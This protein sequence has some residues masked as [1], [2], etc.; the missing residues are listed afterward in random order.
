VVRQVGFRGRE[1]CAPSGLAFG[2][3]DGTAI[4]V[5]SRP[6]V[7]HAASAA[8][9][10]RERTMISTVRPA[11]RV[12][13]AVLVMA[14]GGASVGG[15][16]LAQ[17]PA[18]APPQSGF[19]LPGQPDARPAP[20]P[21][22]PMIESLLVTQTPTLTLDRREINLGSVLDSEKQ[23][24]RIRFRNTGRAML[25]ITDVKG[26]CG[27]TVPALEKRTYAPGEGGELLVKY[28]PH[29]RRGPQHQTVTI[30]SNDPAN[31]RMEIA[32]K[33]D[34]TPV[35][36]VEPMLTQFEA[37]EKAQV[38]TRVIE[39]MGLTPDFAVTGV[40]ISGTTALTATVGEPAMRE[41]DGRMLRVVPVTVA[42]KSDAAPG[43]FAAT[44]TVR[45][46]DAR[47]AVMNTQAMG[48]IQ[49]EL[50]TAPNPIWLGLVA[51]GAPME[52]ELRLSSR[53]G[54]PFMVLGVESREP[55]MR[56][57]KL[58]FQP[59]LSEGEEPRADGKAKE[60]L[61]RVV[62]KAPSQQ[63]A[64]R[65]ELEIRTDEPLEERVRVP[66]FA[67]VREAPQGAA[68][69][70]VRNPDGTP[71]ALPAPARAPAQQ[72]PAR[73]AQ[74]QPQPQPGQGQPAR[75]AQPVPVPR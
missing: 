65:G 2:R 63:M 16:A 34:V 29:N 60:W 31:P 52:S 33:V 32:V 45:T 49:G 13:V 62:A 74:P 24:V 58:T 70:Q 18:N 50:N 11:V 72:A 44:V 4:A 10:T 47:A 68:P 3:D 35:V 43:R 56:D 7:A 12:G 15:V 19:P 17:M 37:V 28:D 6:G 9:Q 61:I 67:N 23:E 30:T 22:G 73:A 26:S 25:N 5:N 41:V 38:T 21:G 42:T 27:C 39:V 54:K 46:N 59:V 69:V 55:N 14:C 64:L 57:A 53:S 36:R 51:P 8:G 40:S 66:L 20:A 48:M 71:R 75:P 1:F